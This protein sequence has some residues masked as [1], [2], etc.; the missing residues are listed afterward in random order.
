MPPLREIKYT[1]YNKKSSRRKQ[2]R[3]SLPLWGMQRFIRQ[4]FKNTTEY[5]VLISLK[6][7]ISG[8]KMNRQATDWE[9]ILIIFISWITH[10]QNT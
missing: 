4:N 2:V 5:N 7:K 6:L 10:T 8:K 1:N 3:I 9:N